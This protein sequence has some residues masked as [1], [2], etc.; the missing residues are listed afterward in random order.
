[1]L[2]AATVAETAWDAQRKHGDVRLQYQSQKQF[3]QLADAFGM[4]AEWRD[5]VPRAAYHGVVSRF[6]RVSTHE[7]LAYGHLVWLWHPCFEVTTGDRMP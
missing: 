2:K 3:E 4:M 5:G 7:G 1:M 6:K